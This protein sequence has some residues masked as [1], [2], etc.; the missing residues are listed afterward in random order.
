MTSATRDTES[1]HKATGR[2]LSIRGLTIRV[3]T[4]K[5][6][7]YPV[8]DLDLDINAGEVV[9]L[10]GETGSGKSM[11]ASSIVGLL[12]RSASIENGAIELFGEDMTDS[13]DK[14]RKELLGRRLGMVLQDPLS[15]LDPVFTVRE[16]VYEPLRFHQRLKGD[17]LKNRAIESLRRM[18]IPNVEQRIN[19]YPHQFSGGMRQRIVGAIAIS[20]GAE[21]LIAD[22]PTTA[23]DV[24]TQAAYLNHLKKLQRDTGMAILFITHDMAIV[25]ALCDRVAVMYAGQVVE[26]GTVSAVMNQPRHPYTHALLQ[27]IPTTTKSPGSRLYTIQGSPPPLYEEREPCAFAPRCPRST[28]ECH[29]A[30]PPTVGN[31]DE[32]RVK[33]WNPL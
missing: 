31:N 14:V 11:T 2:A 18:R 25:R 3:T 24:T 1:D 6:T 20:G 30:Q 26:Q 9:G 29:T 32:R 21:L 19:D 4:S 33:C 5:G 15:A 17:A 22:E 12:P 13:P 23:L 10:V 27:A 8:R 28:D 7:A 16:Q